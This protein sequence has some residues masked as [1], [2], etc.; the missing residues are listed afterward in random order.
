MTPTYAAL[1]P[2]ATATSTTSH[3]RDVSSVRHEPPLTSSYGLGVRNEPTSKGMAFATLLRTA[4]TER[5]LTQG[6]VIANTSVSRSTYLRW[7][8]GDA[9]LPNIDQVRD[10]CLYLGIRPTVAAVALG[11]LTEEELGYLFDPIVVEIGEILFDPSTSPAARAA[12]RH[13]LDAALRLWRMAV[14]MPEPI[15]PSG[16]SLRRRQQKAR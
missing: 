15:E 10:V 3:G 1:S 8:S 16:E 5:G 2:S 14:A 11:L 13:S 9:Q 12:L 6:D 7:E 4:R